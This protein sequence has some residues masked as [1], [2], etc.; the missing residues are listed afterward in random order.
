[1][2]QTSLNNAI[3]KPKKVLI[4]TA[5]EDAS[6]ST[7]A[8][9]GEFCASGGSFIAEVAGPDEVSNLNLARAVA[10]MSHRM[11]DFRPDLVLVTDCSE[12]S[13]GAALAAFDDGVRVGHFEAQ[14]ASMTQTALKRNELIRRIAAFHFATELGALTRLAKDNVSLDAVTLVGNGAD[15]EKASRVV[16]FLKYRI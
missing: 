9:L 3:D 14:T 6:V 13:L 11:A 1:M 8:L 4:V 7:D 12:L 10:A 2:T 15:A 5:N 16:A